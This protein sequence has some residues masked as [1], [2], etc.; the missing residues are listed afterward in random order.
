ML[1]LFSVL[2]YYIS[3][4]PKCLLSLLIYVSYH[5][6][7]AV[8]GDIVSLKAKKLG[9]RMGPVRSSRE[10]NL[11]EIGLDI[12]SYHGKQFIGNHCNE[13]LKQNNYTKI[14]ECKN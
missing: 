11:N 1:F 14:L 10:R 5:R 3:Q 12:Q 7:T 2:R 4:N 9:D 6:L 8:T 13:Y